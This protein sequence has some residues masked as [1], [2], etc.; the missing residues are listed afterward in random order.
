MGYTEMPKQFLFLGDKPII[1]HTAEKFWLNSKFTKIYVGVPADWIP[2]T[3]EIFEKYL[4]K[5]PKIEIVE[6][7]ATRNGTILNIINVIKNAYEI[8]D[9]D[10]IVTHDAVRPFLTHRIINENIESALTYGACDTI[11]PATDTIV[12]SQDGNFLSEIPDRSK[13]YLGQTPQ[14][15]KINLF[16]RCY[17]KLDEKQKSILTDACKVLVL[18]G[19]KV[20]NVYGEDY[21]IKITT[22][23]D[24]KIANAL[25]EIGEC[26]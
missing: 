14:S 20:K 12:F 18:N 8:T 21:N 23:F 4:G 7:G 17:D 26:K 25:L 5:N 15:F 13:I 19:E 22:P 24:L 1:I 2:H 10:I 3:R 11:I 9:D 16:L 6:G